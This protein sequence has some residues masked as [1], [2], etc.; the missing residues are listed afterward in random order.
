MRLVY[1]PLGAPGT[2]TA[3]PTISGMAF[4]LLAL[5]LGFVA[6]RA[7]RAGGRLSSWALAAGLAA[8]A[9]SG[10]GVDLIHHAH[11]INAIGPVQTELD[12]PGGG[13]API[14]ET[15]C[16]VFTNTSGVDQ[17]VVSV[18]VS[19]TRVSEINPCN[20]GVGLAQDEAC[21]VNCATDVEVCGPPEQGVI[22]F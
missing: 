6:V 3:V 13:T 19:C 16:N 12:Q 15:A 14:D 4:I 2:A 9:S 17:Q 18:D 5:A 21:A 1:R 10:V 7:L 11:A 22:A 8:L 20:A